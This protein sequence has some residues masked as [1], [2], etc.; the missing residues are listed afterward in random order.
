MGRLPAEE[1]RRFRKYTS[2]GDDNYTRYEGLDEREHNFFSFLFSLFLLLF[3][4][5]NLQ[6]RRGGAQREP[7]V[8]I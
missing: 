8:D 1:Q 4:R 3:F 2:N 7:R 5:V 6:Q